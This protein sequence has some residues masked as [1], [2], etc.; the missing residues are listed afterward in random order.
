MSIP[1]KWIWIMSI[2]V[3]SKIIKKLEH[4]WYSYG[5]TVVLPCKFDL[6]RQ[7]PLR[8]CSENVEIQCL[9]Y[10][11]PPLGGVISGFLFPHSRGRSMEI[12]SWHSLAMVSV[13]H[14]MLRTSLTSHSKSPDGSTVL[15]CQPMTIRLELRCVNES[16]APVYWVQLVP[17]SRV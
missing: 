17:C 14:H 4:W 2:A 8:L 7:I 9:C 15:D 10:N 16:L 1:L 3:R 13:P 12:G 5:N 6:W 11:S